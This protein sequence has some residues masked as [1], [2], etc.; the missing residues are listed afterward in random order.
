M[1]GHE[2]LRGG[3]ALADGPDARGGGMQHAVDPVGERRHALGVDLLAKDVLKDVLDELLELHPSDLPL[4][5]AAYFHNH[6][7]AG[8]GLPSSTA[9][10]YTEVEVT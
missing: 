8:D 2:A 1:L 5:P 4:R 6:S 9:E 7:P 10:V 3:Q